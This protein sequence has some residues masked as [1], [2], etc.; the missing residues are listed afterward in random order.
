MKTYRLTLA[1]DGLDFHGW[2][3]QS[4]ERSVQGALEG[5]LAVI[6]QREVKVFGAGRTDAGVHAL[7]Q[8][9]SFQVEDQE[10]GPERVLASLRGLLPEDITAIELREVHPDFHARF[11]ATGRHYLYRIGLG[12]CAPFRRNRWETHYALDLTRMR[13]ALAALPGEHDF[14]AFCKAESAE[15]GTRCHMRYAELASVGDELHLT[16]GADRFLHNM[17]R[18]ITGTLVDVGRGHFEP[19]IV[20]ELLA[21]GDRSRGGNTAPPHG[22]YLVRVDYPDEFL[23][24]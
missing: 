10:H 11:K 18:I 5:A 12:A 7:G 13:K 21:S 4:A 3:I 24:P 17:V 16:L 2:Q 22:L 19:D 9:A 1:Y 14:R 15:K 6:F 23:K 20:S 8:C